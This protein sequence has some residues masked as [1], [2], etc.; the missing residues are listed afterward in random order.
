MKRDERRS[1]EE[2]ETVAAVSVD[3]AVAAVLAELDSVFT[4]RTKNGTE[5]FSRQTI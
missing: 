2:L 4:L 1:C 5:G 3:A